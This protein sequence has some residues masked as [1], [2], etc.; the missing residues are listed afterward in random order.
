MDII[1]LHLHLQILYNKNTYFLL[2]LKMLNLHEVFLLEC[3]WSDLLPPSLPSSAS[4]PPP[5]SPSSG[6]LKLSVSF[7]VES[8]ESWSLPG[9]GVEPA[10]VE[11][12]VGGAP[13]RCKEGVSTCVGVRLSSLR[14]SLLLSVDVEAEERLE[15][16]EYRYEL[17]SSPMEWRED[18]GVQGSLVSGDSR[19]NFCRGLREKKPL[20][21]LYI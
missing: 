18:S 2:F 7:R 3:L 6:S 19:R 15:L 12:N 1:F 14:K 5:S 16:D 11:Q 13:T 20:S 8:L 10:G 9:E 4:T 21:S 17:L